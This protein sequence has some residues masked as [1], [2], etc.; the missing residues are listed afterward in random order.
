MGLRIA[1]C[2]ALLVALTCSRPTLA[3]ETTPQDQLKAWGEALEGTWVNEQNL[4]VDLPGIGEK[5]DVLRGEITYE[6]KGG[7]YQAT[8]KGTVNG[9]P[10][11][12]GIGVV[13]W[14]AA[15]G[16]VRVQW[17]TNKGSNAI[18]LWKPTKNG[19]RKS[20]EMTSPDGVKSTNKGKLTVAGN[21][22]E[23]EITNRKRG[24]ESL[25]KKK[26]T[27]TKQK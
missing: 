10:T 22:H 14:D 20:W 4:D 12:S 8:W 15:K 24:K 11:D 26:E 27:W 3:E 23:W 6:P 18:D 2:A 16:A 1:T 25:P 9:K 21:R 7:L 5:G 17:F 13:G 19:W